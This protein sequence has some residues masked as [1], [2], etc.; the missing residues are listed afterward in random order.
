MKKIYNLLLTAVALVSGLSLAACSD[1]ETYTAGAESRGAYVYS[2]ATSYTFLPADAQTFTVNVGR[3]YSDGEKTVELICDNDY[4]VDAATQ[5]TFHEGETSVAVP[6]TVSLE[7][8]Q[9]E[10]FVFSVPN[11]EGTV[12]GNDS[13]TI[14]VSRDYTWEDVG[15]AAFTDPIFEVEGTVIVQ[16]AAE[17]DNLYRFYAPYTTLFSQNGETVLPGEAHIQFTLDEDGTVDLTQRGFIDLE[18]GTSLVGY[19]LYYVPSYYP[20]YCYIVNENG[21]ISIVSLFTNGTSLYGPGV[22]EFD[23]NNGYPYAQED[24]GDEPT[25]DE[26]N[27][28][29][30][31]DAE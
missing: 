26:G 16:K 2:A 11:G 22:F 4:I 3:T 31:A 15:S 28:E 30:D 8:G 9:S 6:V 29:G 10:D 27:A 18:T 14:T 21:L 19:S 25:E 5:V 24:E 20:D 17:A 13:L 7:I 12:Y 1:D 23:W